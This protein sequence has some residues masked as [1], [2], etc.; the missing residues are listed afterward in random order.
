MPLQRTAE[1]PAMTHMLVRGRQ[2]AQSHRRGAN[3][4]QTPCQRPPSKCPHSVATGV[5]VLSGPPRA[6]SWTPTQRACSATAMSLGAA[7]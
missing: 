3:P 2:G 4:K 6:T 7:K 5:G 1:V